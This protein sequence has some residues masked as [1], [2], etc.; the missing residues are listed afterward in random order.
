MENKEALYNAVLHLGDNGSILGH[1]LGEL[2]GH[3]PVLEQDIAMTNIALDLIGQARLYLQYA[4]KLSGKDLTED[5]LAYKRDV[6]DYKNF[7]IT[8]LQNGDFADTIARQF[9]YDTFHL[10]FLRGLSDSK[11]ETLAAIAKKSIKEVTYHQRW[12]CE[13]VIRLGDGTD[14]SHE[15]MQ[16][17]LNDIWMWTDELFTQSEDEGSLVE[18]GM[19][20]DTSLLKDQWLN[21][22]KRI[23]EEAALDMPE[24]QPMQEGGKT[25]YHTEYLGFILAEMQY[26]PRAYPDATW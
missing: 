18:S 24:D 20:P 21:E 2:C 16:R 15:K 25:G 26:L 19:L 5:D 22:I 4:G 7:L 1:R 23:V 13:W 3:G 10:L 14:E 12:S 6:M 8:E 17:A 11:D 9:T